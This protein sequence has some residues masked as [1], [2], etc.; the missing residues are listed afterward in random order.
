MDCDSGVSHWYRTIHSIIVRTVCVMYLDF[1]IATWFVIVYVINQGTPS[2]S[3][4]LHQLCI[5]IVGH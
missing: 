2:S 3:G 5:C 4:S 1:G